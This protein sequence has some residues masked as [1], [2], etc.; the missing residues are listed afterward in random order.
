MA[1]DTSGGA[2]D[3]VHRLY[4]RQKSHPL[5]SRQQDL[6]DRVLPA[7]RLDLTKQAP[8]EL[9]TLFD[10]DV[11]ETWLE[12]G[13]GGGEHLAWQLDAH[14]DV[15]IIGCEPFLNGI[16]KLLG[17]IPEEQYRRLRLHDHDARDVVEW[18]PDSSLT[19]VFILFPDPW[20]KKR[21]RK[22]RILTPAF[23]ELLAEKLKVGAEL[24]FATDIDD[25][26]RTGLSALL[27]ECRLEWSAQT[28]SDWRERPAD[29]PGTRYGEK[30]E[31]E[32]RSSAYFSFVRR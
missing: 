10:A 22:R 29:W 6:I 23:V 11:T 19:R 26:K 31:R 9:T 30:A 25:Y 21:H 14:Q 4:G 2:P 28:A 17:Q 32:G 27:N 12:I 7:R 13:F 3:R 24:R 5:S 1:K 18:L 8:S 15:G 20:P 16:A